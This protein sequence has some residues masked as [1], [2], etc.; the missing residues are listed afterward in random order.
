MPQTAPTLRYYESLL[1]YLR[2]AGREFAVA[3]PDRARS[4]GL[5]R[6]CA[7]DP[8]VERLFE[9]MAFLMGHVEQRLDDDLPELTE[10]LVNM[11]WP[12]YLRMIPSLTVV[13]WVAQRNTLQHNEMIQAGLPI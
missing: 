1:R 4:L 2:S 8:A 6:D 11:L 3:H 10:G 7:E 12:Q 9:G 13:K 5:S